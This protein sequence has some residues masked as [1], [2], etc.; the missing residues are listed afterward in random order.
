MAEARLDGQMGPETDPAVVLSELAEHLRPVFESTPGGVY[1]YL[2]AEHK[3][4]NERLARLFG[5]TVAEW[6][7]EPHFQESFVAEEDR[8]LYC[9]TYGR[10]VHDFEG[11]ATYR[12]RGR[13]KDGSFFAAEALL[14]PLTYKGQKFA[15]H[16]VR[17]VIEPEL[18]PY[19][20]TGPHGAS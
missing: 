1:L 5:R 12:F 20:S 13:R 19:A 10:V 11:P 18:W 9:D 16:F 14:V 8:G 17:E 3:I 2:D 4:C 6:C 7:R 15:Y